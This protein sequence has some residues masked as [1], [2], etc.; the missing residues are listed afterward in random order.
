MSSTLFSPF[1][2]RGLEIENRIVV[3]SMCQYSARDGCMGDWHLMHL[4]QYAV[5][6]AGLVMTEM[7]DVAPEGRIGPYCVGL[8]SE[9]TEAAMRR[10]V[11]FCRRHGRARFGLQLAHAGRKSSVLPPWEGRRSVALE[12]GG[13]QPVAPSPLPAFQDGLT[14]R[15][16]TLADLEEL[17][18]RFVDAVKRAERIGFDLIELHG[19]HGYLVHQFLSPITNHRS[20][21]YGGSLENR[22]RFPLEIFAAMRGAWPAD[23]PLGVKLSAVDW[24][25]GGW[26]M[27]DTLEYCC[28]LRELGCDFAVVSTGGIVWVE[29]IPTAPGFQVP[30]AAEIRR[31]T[32]MAVSASGLITEPTQAERIV[33]SG[34]A[35]LVSI[36]R[37]MLWEPRW[38]WHAAE[39]L[40][41]DI[42]F[43]NQYARAQ[44][45]LAH[46]TFATGSAFKRAV[47]DSAASPEQ[48][49][50][51]PVPARPSATR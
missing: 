27:R 37:A 26:T 33:A 34:E 20:D 40:G 13:W 19:A 1:R 2:L 21:A 36:A 30:F 7:T 4:G 25:E 17:K 41:A 45:R 49:S 15:E 6:G 24:V 48:H 38:A 12:E 51:S 39:V 29:S 23:K 44:P 16:L 47:A 5:S 18:V 9:E 22:M 8:Y 3:A 46:D 42:R 11:E 32:G 28:R 31:V 50:S 43:P 14:P 10:V 35:D